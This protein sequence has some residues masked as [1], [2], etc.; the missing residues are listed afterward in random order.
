MLTSSK[1]LDCGPNAFRQIADNNSFTFA[2]NHCALDYI[3]EFAHVSGEIIATQNCQ[4][5]GTNSIRF[6]T[7]LCCVHSQKEFDELLQVFSS[8]PQWRQMNVQD[9]QP[10]K[11]ILAKVTP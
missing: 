5:I 1:H 4:N 3:S 6:T 2:N 11:K 7:V 10:I 9:I 8:F